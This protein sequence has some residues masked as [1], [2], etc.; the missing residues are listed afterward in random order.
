[1]NL[2]KVFDIY[3]QFLLLTRKHD[4]FESAKCDDEGNERLLLRF[5][6]GFTV[7]LTNK[8]NLDN[9]AALRCWWE[10]G[11]TVEVDSLEKL[12]LEFSNSN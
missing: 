8:R 6:C 10:G 1:M 9:S 7:E 12:L 11:L 2:D 4:H 3:E 5:N